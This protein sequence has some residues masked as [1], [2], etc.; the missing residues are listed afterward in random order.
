MTDKSV[1]PVKSVQMLQN[2]FLLVTFE[3]GEK[4]YVRS[5]VSA[6]MVAR[7]RQRKWGELLQVGAANYVG[8]NAIQ[9]KADNV[10][11]V[12]Q[13]EYDGNALYRDGRRSYIV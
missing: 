2:L 4:R 11:A 12:N 3:D 10:F 6:Q 8:G 7:G 5:P 9:L 13:V 1:P